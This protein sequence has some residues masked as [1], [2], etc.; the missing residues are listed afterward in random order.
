LGLVDELRASGELDRMAEALARLTERQKIVSLAKELV[1]PAARKFG[2][3]PVFRNLWKRLGLPKAIADAVDKETFFAYDMEAATFRMV[4]GRL[5]DP[6]SKLA[7]HRWAKKVYWDDGENVD[8]PH[9]YRALGVLSRNVKRMEENLYF[10]GRD[11]FTPAPDLLFFDTT[12]VYFEGEGPTGGLGQYYYSKDNRPDRKQM[13]VGVVLTREGTPLAHHVFPGN[14][15]DAAAFSVVIEEM[16]NRFGIKRV[17]LVGDRGMFNASVIKRI[18]ELEME[19][20]AGVK[21]RTVWDVRE[22]V[23][24]NK[25]P[26]ETVS[27]NLKVKKVELGGK[28]Y[29][30]CL[31]EEEAKRAKAIREEVIAEL[32]E[33]IAQGPKRLVGHS[34][35]RKYVHLDKDAVSVNEQKIIDEKKYDGKYVLLTNTNLSAKEAALAYKG[36]WQVERAFREIKSTFEIRPVYLSREDHVRGHVAICFLAFCLQVAFRKAIG[37]A[38]E[39]KNH[40]FE[41]LL[42]SLKEVRMIELTAGDK[43]YRVRT[44][45]DEIATAIFR[46]VGAAIPR[47]VTMLEPQPEAAQA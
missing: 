31:N 24:E 15:P 27:E 21:M 18:E 42:E 44:E 30:V 11:L 14:T 32:R 20:I 2:P 7:T 34:L 46:A 28:T 29:V 35:Y 17:I 39:L 47:R 37:D 9:Y 6:K 12:S 40:S 10:A 3:V 5:L 43:S 13:I 38:E 8:L 4:L 41:S 19:Y 25:A 22:I 33:K 36:L 16:R 26:F 45:P 23:L 1:A